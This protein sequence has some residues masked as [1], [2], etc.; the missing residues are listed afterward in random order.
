[1]K[2]CIVVIQGQE[3]D[4]P[5]FETDSL[6]AAKAWATRNRYYIGRLTV[7]CIYIR[8]LDGRVELAAIGEYNRRTRRT[9]WTNVD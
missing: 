1:M 2:A 4:S 5:L 9:K 7:P 3:M 6:K 8:L